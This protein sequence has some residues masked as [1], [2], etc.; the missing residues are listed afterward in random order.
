MWSSV[1]WPPPLSVIVPGR[2]LASSITSFT[3]LNLLSGFT[4]HML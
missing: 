4:A 1:P 3:V 2:F